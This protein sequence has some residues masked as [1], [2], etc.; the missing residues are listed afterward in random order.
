MK[1]GRELIEDI[2]ACTVARGECAFWWLGQLGL[3]VKLG[4][5]V[6]W[7]DAYLAESPRRQV[8]PLEQ[9]GEVTNADAILGTHDHS[10]H[11]DRKSWPGMAA[12]SPKALFVVPDMVREKLVKEVGLPD[13]RVKGLDDGRSITVGDVKI[14]GVPAAHELLDQD[15]ATK[16]F[17]YLGYVLE[18]NGFCLYHSG[19]TCLY[20]GMH[21]KLRQWKLDLALMPINGR[22]AKRLAANTIG[23]MTYQETV[24]LAGAVRPGF[25][26]PGH[27]DMFA[28]NGEDPQLFADYMR[29]K[30]PGLKC[31]IPKHGERV[32]VE[33]GEEVR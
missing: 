1:K 18:G 4:R 30:Y 2:N 5:T 33:A 12:A 32:I 14:T 11:I 27:W 26:I 23:N 24:D 29:V 17:P 6:C 13:G 15:P 21:T 10:D 25:T 28:H 9:H 7:I 8:P 31:L 22:D 16:R 20:E 3:V 19:D